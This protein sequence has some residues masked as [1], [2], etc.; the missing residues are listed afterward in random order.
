MDKYDALHLMF[1][2]CGAYVMPFI[3]RRLMLPSSVG[4]LL[5]GMMLASFIVP[6]AAAAEP[7]KLLSQ[8]GFIL[9][10]YIAGLELDLDRISALNRRE[11]AA[12]VL[13]AV[14]LVAVSL[15]VTVLVGLPL[16]FALV[17]MTCAIGLLFTVLKDMDLVKTPL[18][19]TLILISAVGEILTLAGI[20]LVSLI[21]RSGT[22]R[23]T[24]FQVLGIVLFVTAVFLVMRV[25]NLFLWWY[26]EMKR[27]FMSVG[28]PSEIG[29][30]AN[31]ANMFIFVALAYFVGLEAILGAF[32]GGMIFA[33]LF[34]DREEMLERLS[35]FGYGF[36]IPLFFIEVG[37]R[38]RIT[39]FFV[40]QVLF[41]AVTI[42]LL[43]LLVRVVS[44]LPLL[45]SGVKL[46]S[47]PLVSLSLSF[48]LTLLVAVAA[49]GDSLKLIDHGQTSVIIL[50]AILT[51]IFYPWFMK[52]Y[53]RAVPVAE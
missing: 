31:L 47:L 45:Y 36:L 3:S 41:G 9:L 18:G 4:E 24:L 15:G 29:V 28:N 2:T 35:S 43:M 40:P 38:F 7:L 42:A 16:F 32:L 27:F 37:T 11:L 46:R 49:T 8:L 39:D 33:K 52:L 6:T 5:F 30:R 53:G 50:T 20:T 51:A 12:Y 13:F 14:L 22:T 25:L 48:P 23:E 21:A 44:S 1:A 19:Q 17:I 26:P 34:A 10:M